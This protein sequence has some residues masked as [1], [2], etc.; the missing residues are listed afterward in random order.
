MMR[1][2]GLARSAECQIVGIPET[3]RARFWAK[4]HFFDNAVIRPSELNGLFGDNTST[5]YEAFQMIPIEVMSCNKR[6]LCVRRWN[7]ESQDWFRIA[8]RERVL[9]SC[10][11][12]RIYTRNGLRV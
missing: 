1:K 5:D 7:V 3:G 9:S 4:R 11:V 6:F 2:W 8:P 12:D 10:R